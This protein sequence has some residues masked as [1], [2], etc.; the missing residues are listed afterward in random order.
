[1]LDEIRP[2][3]EHGWSVHLLKPH[4]KAP[5]S[6]DWSTAR[7]LTFP[8]IRRLY[9]KGQNVGVRLGRPSRVD[10]GFLYAFDFD[11]RV[12][13][14][15]DEAMTAFKKLLPNVKISNC[16]RVQSGSR[17]DSFHAYF[18][19]TDDFPSRK[20]AN[21]GIKFTDADGKK[22]WTWEI[23]LFGTGK[24]IALPPS[25]HPLT[26]RT[27]RWIREPVFE[28]G[29]PEI[30]AGLLGDLVFGREDEDGEMPEND[31]LG[32]SYAE[33][34]AYLADL[35]LDYWC[36]D[37]EGWRNTG[38]ALHHEFDGSKDAF[39]LWVD[40][41]KQSRKFEMDVCKEQWRSFR[42][43]KSRPIR[44]AT[45]IQA[46]HKGALDAEIAALDDEPAKSPEKTAGGRSD[47]PDMSIIQQSRVEAPVFPLDIFGPLLAAEIGA[48]AE[49]ASSPVDF[50]A[51]A[52]LCGASAMIGNTNRVQVKPGFVQPAVLWAQVIGPPSAK[53]SPALRVVTSIIHRI[54]ARYEPYYL[55]QLERWEM[56]SARAEANRKA[57][58]G[59][60]K[61]MIAE[62]HEGAEHMRPGPECEVPPEPVRKQFIINDMT[63]EAFHRA[64]ARI[65]RGFMVYRDEL[66]GWM[67][68]MERYSAESERGAWLES[69]D[70]GSYAI[71]RVK[72]G[73]KTIRIRHICAP[74]LGG[75]QPERLLSIT[76]QSVVDDGL[77]ARFM[78]F[79]PEHE[80]IPMAERQKD[81]TWLTDLF[82]K[83]SELGMDEDENGKPIPYIRPFTAEAFA[84]FKAWSDK[85]E[86]DEAYVPT[87]LAG[88][89]G[90]STGQVAR[91]AIVLELLWWAS[92]PDFD[93]GDERPPQEISAKAVRAAIRFREVYLKIMQ[94]RVYT[95]SIETEEVKNARLI[96]EWIVDNEV[97]VFNARTMR[98]EAGIKGISNKTAVE[99]V[100]DA[101]AVLVSMRWV[102]TEDKKT[103]GRHSKNYRVNPK[104]FE[105][106]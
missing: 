60:L 5:T 90:K 101:I 35:D 65:A 104:I 3:V 28:I 37:R 10:G 36:D 17:G 32:I 96:A 34:E 49:N 38:M 15:A 86:Q 56:D 24:Q 48:H 59:K 47:D 91:L 54:E 42:N 11:I 43:T 31:V 74:V 7:V 68:N 51:A 81:D 66:A 33:A 55:Q 106:I 98:R 2:L 46:A 13:G 82:Q 12:A 105:L 9:R 92:A 57:F 44:M 87:R 63:I 20:I 70:G 77:Q 78:P 93:E 14:V 73:G 22:H 1:M 26:G 8:E 80:F 25:I 19:S 53:K 95:H 72:D 40:F 75:I 100:D 30:D 71:E 84:I 23:E 52:V 41:S 39:R 83:L 69:Y 67:G 88:A 79:W 99:V 50:A 89:Y 97:E 76:A 6:A 21:S 18:I 27:Y 45:I 103:G 85:R 64:Q 29:L 16:P 94:R 61:A 4:S 58:D 62:G 102:V